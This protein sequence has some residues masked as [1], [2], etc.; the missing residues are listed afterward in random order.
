LRFE[1]RELPKSYYPTWELI[2]DGVP[3]NVEITRYDVLTTQSRK[4]A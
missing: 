3:T 2:D 4:E 1:W